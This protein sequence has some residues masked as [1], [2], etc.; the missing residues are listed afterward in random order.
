MCNAFNI[1]RLNKLLKLKTKLKTTFL[2]L[3]PHSYATKPVR[4]L[5]SRVDLGP[6][7]SKLNL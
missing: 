3:L 5:A 4:Q 7:L 1:E 2:V 6:V